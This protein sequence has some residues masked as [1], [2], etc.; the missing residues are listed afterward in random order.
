MWSKVEEE[1]LT[2]LICKC[3][4]AHFTVEIDN[5]PRRNTVY[6]RS[7]NYAICTK[8]NEAHYI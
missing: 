2:N 1:N 6:S 5:R 7:K 3:G 8:C 4:N